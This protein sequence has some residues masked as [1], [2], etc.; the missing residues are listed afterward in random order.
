MIPCALLILR[1]GCEG[2][3]RE[4]VAMVKDHWWLNLHSPLR[5]RTTEGF[6][7]CKTS[8]IRRVNAGSAREKAIGET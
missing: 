5:W 8:W 2:V 1:D 3:G 4:M 7:R 6:N